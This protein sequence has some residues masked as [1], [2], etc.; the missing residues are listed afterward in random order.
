MK[1]I[2]IASVFGI[3]LFGSPST[4]SSIELQSDR[5]FYLDG[6]PVFCDSCNS[7]FSLIGPGKTVQPLQFFK[8]GPMYEDYFNSEIGVK[9]S[10][11][12]NEQLICV[13]IFDLDKM[14]EEVLVQL[15]HKDNSWA[16]DY[17][18]EHGKVLIP[19]DTLLVTDL[20]LYN[21]IRKDILHRDVK[22]ILG[23]ETILTYENDNLLLTS[24]RQVD[25]K[26]Y[27]IEF[28]ILQDDF[29]DFQK[30]T[31]LK[32]EI[33]PFGSGDSANTYVH[34]VLNRPWPDLKALF[35]EDNM[36][37]FSK[38]SSGNFEANI[39]FSESE[40]IQDGRLAI[41]FGLEEVSISKNETG[42]TWSL[43]SKQVA[44][45]NS[46]KVN[47]INC[48]VRYRFSSE[49]KPGYKTNIMVEFK[50]FRF[51]QFI[52]TYL[53]YVVLVI[54]VLIMWLLNGRKKKA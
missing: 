22:L 44:A 49:I 39:P 32:W 7:V 48:Q 23:Y 36:I 28:N 40:L 27:A 8:I 38:T 10:T 42:L 52:K 2:I 50:E 18:K 37:I 11:Q 46:E 29:P 14:N 16:N 25:M 17:L 19:L 5:G 13:P 30:T 43:S 31:I 4:L 21:K 45:L 9:F 6:G 15:F 41:Y 1:N 26:D 53:F 54:F 35:P 33:S 47:E 34:Y 12:A 51:L 24:K 20:A 3:C